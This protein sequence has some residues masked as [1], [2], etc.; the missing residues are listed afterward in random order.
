MNPLENTLSSDIPV[1]ARLRRG[2]R[3]V[4]GLLESMD[5]NT[6]TAANRNR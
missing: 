5:P 6:V 2:A 3:L 4:L 1:E